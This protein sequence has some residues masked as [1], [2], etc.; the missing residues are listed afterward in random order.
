VYFSPDCKY[1]VSGSIDRTII[2]YNLNRK[3]LNFGNVSHKI[4][5]D[6]GVNKICY[7]KNGDF[8]V[9]SEFDTKVFIY[10]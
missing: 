10:I 9:V 8:F 2:F 5:N 1:F 6:V 3:S 4:N 7:S